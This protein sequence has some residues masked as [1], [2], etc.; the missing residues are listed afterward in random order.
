M[1]TNF[2]IPTRLRAGYTLMLRT[3]AADMSAHGGF[4]W[5]RSGP[6]ECPDWQPT[7]A[8]GN[9]LHGLLRGCGR[10][11]LLN[12]DEGAMW[13]VVEILASDVI[14]LDGKIKVPRGRVLFA[15]VR[16]EALALMQRLGHLDEAAVG[17]TLTGGDGATLTGGDRATLTGG[18]GATLTGGDGAT[19]TGGYRAT[20][21]G[22]DRA[23]LTGGDRA[24]FLVKWWDSKA[25]RW[26]RTLAEVGED[27]IVAGERYQFEAGKFIR[28][29]KPAPPAPPAEEATAQ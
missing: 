13:L 20:L 6:V 12:W 27:G 22:G 26:R 21:T 29:E 10:G 23:T 28:I 4:V 1:T 24:T 25:E 2:K 5:P 17:A 16:L 8:C 11:S 9:G 7:K 19:L 18:V 14:D 3:C 15:G